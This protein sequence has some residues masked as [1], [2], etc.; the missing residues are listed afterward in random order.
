MDSTLTTLAHYFTPSSL[1]ATSIRLGWKALSAALVLLIGLIVIRIVMSILRSALKRTVSDVTVRIYSENATRIVLWV[2]LLV[3]ILGVFGIETTALAAL[4]GAA[5]LA[6]GLAL[7]GSLSNFAAGFMLLIFRPFKAGDVVEVAGVSGK[8][9]E[10]DI[11]STI[12]DTP[13]NIR[14]FVPNGAIFN[15][16]IRNRSANE[17]VRTELRVSV[18]TGSD[19]QRVLQIVRRT[20]ESNDLVAATPRPD[21]H[22]VDDP[23]AGITVA[24]RPYVRLEYMDAMKTA[25]AAAVRE[26]LR[27]AEINVLR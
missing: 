14:T 25:V 5:G 4:L 15:G 18:E 17:Y 8:V 20:L 23:G 9:I 12:I 19:M 3:M 11:F 21:V 7:Q 6:I 27:A 10:I 2:V 16:V 13:E 26:A 1:A 22:I 24:M